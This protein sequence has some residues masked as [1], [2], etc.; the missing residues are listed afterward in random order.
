MPQSTTPSLMRHAAHVQFGLVAAA[1]LG[2]VLMPRPGGAVLLI[3]LLKGSVGRV[4]AGPVAVLHAGW[5]RGSMLVRVK[6]PVPVWGLLRRGVLPL[7][8]PGFSCGPNTGADPEIQK[9]A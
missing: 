3:P 6:G 5:L 2:S 7:G 4:D 8:T 9:A 1:L